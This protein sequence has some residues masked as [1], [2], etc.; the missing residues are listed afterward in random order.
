MRD[1]KFRCW[2]PKG[3]DTGD[4]EIEKGE[5]CYALA[6]EEYKP[7]NDLLKGVEHLMQYTG[8][9]DKNKKDIYEGDILKWTAGDGDIAEVYWMDGDCCFD[10]RPILNGL[11]SAKTMYY[12]IIGNIYETPELLEAKP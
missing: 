6:F 10:T 2:F 7:I 12:E 8:L 1:I 9:K 11:S 4:G 5:M 3:T